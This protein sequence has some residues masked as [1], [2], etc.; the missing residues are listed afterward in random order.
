MGRVVNHEGRRSGSPRPFR[1]LVLLLDYREPG[2]I[3]VDLK[4]VALQP[5][6]WKFLLRLAEQPGVVV[7]YKEL[8]DELWGETVVELNQLSFQKTH[9]LGAVAAVAPR[10]RDMILTF[11]KAGFMLDLSPRE[12][13][14]VPGASMAQMGPRLGVHS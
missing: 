13:L 9:V 5:L 7:R 4:P 10:R 12:V 14:I 6:G 8:Y 3:L 11:P 1:H 2:Y